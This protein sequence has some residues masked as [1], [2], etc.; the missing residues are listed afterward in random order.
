MDKRKRERERRRQ[1][2]LERLGADRP[3]C[4][5]CAEA[6]ERCLE[7]HHIAGQEF[8]DELAIICRNCQRKLSDEQID[9]PKAITK[10][11]HKLERIGHF[12]IGL[13]DLFRLIAE[14]LKQYGNHLIELAREAIDPADRR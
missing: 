3:V 4:T 1:R 12:L 9:H 7:R 13:A 8:G 14:A 6:D 10:P 2:R 11:P 5:V